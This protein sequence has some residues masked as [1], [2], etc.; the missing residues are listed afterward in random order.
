M[1]GVLGPAFSTL[2]LWVLLPSV[3]LGEVR[4]DGGGV[5]SVPIISAAMEAKIC[6]GSMDATTP[7]PENRVYMYSLRTFRLCAVPL[8]HGWPMRRRISIQFHCTPLRMHQFEIMSFLI[9]NTP[10]R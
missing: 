2:A 1:S 8:L 6:Q 9:L 4:T 3:G 5:I 7:R 10:F